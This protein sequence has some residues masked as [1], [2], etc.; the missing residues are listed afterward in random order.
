MAKAHKLPSGNWNCKAY[1]HSEPI[2]NPNGSPV[3]LSNGKQKMQRIYE[4]FT[5]PT[6]KEAEFLAAQFQLTKAEKLKQQADE[7]NKT[8]AEKKLDM[9]LYE[10]ISIYIESRKLL[11]RS[12]TTIQEYECTQKYGF[13]DI[14]DMKLSDLDE[15]ILQEAINM[16]SQRMS[17][18]RN[19]RKPIGSKRLKNEWGLV[20]ATLHKFHK[21]L[22]YSVELPE[23]PD[24][25]PDLLSAEELLPAVKG[26]E[27]ELA[28]LLAAWLSFSMSEVRGLTKSKSIS[29]DY[30]RI[31][32]VVVDVHGRPVTKEIAKNKYRNR[33][34]R[35]PPYIKQLIDTVPG[36][37]LVPFNGRQLYH[38][39]IKFLDK[40]HFHHMTFHDL[41][42]L[43]ASVMAWLQIPDKYAQERG[44]WKSDKVMK[45]VYTQTFPQARIEVDN[46]IDNFFDGIVDPGSETFNYEKYNAWR[47]LFDKKDTKENRRN[48]LEW[49]QHEMQHEN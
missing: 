38:K 10:A 2:Y 32:E 20:A 41:R 46:T 5:A 8:S 23:V 24:R 34:H 6:K 39:W 9:T 27:I 22:V 36:D 17:C 44:G 7:Q 35:I 29:G 3:I 47:L 31:V 28:V 33:T 42:H 18:G 40:H 25:V 37:V 15:E 19:K 21:A 16:E 13:Q 12:P 48:F 45:K 11:G 49:M 14:M 30:I 1:S 4:S 43:N 26:T